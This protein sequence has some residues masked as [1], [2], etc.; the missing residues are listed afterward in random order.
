MHGR[1]Q[2]RALESRQALPRTIERVMSMQLSIAALGSDLFLKLTQAMDSRRI[3]VIFSEDPLA[4]G[5]SIG[6][7][8]DKAKCDFQGSL[9]HPP[10]VAANV[11]FPAEI[12]H[13]IFD[14]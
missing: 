6:C 13:H 7:A 1:L 4:V 11:P 9:F 12:F 10:I 14:P 8:C 2:R 3:K 5:T